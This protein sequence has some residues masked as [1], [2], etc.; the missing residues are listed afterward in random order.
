MKIECELFINSD[1]NQC[2]YPENG[3]DCNGDCF[4][5]IDE[6]GICGGYG[7]N[8]DANLD[9]IVNIIDVI[10]IIDHIILNTDINICLI[11]LNQNNV[12]NITDIIILLEN[13]LND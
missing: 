1:E 6:C 4:F 10:I 8:G 2:I 13:I 5:E 7:N 11:D 12:I 3:F 9:G